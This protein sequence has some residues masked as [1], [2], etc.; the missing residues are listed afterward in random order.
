MRNSD[1]RFIFGLGLVI[2]GLIFGGWNG[3]GLA[4]NLLDEKLLSVR[5]IGMGGILPI[6]VH[7]PSV[8][9]FNPAGLGWLES[10]GLSVEGYN[11][12]VSSSNLATTLNIG[13]LGISRFRREDRTNHKIG[14]GFRPLPWFSWGLS[15][16]FDKKRGGSSINAG[17][18]ISPRPWLD[19]GVYQKSLVW[20]DKKTQNH[21]VVSLTTR[22]GNGKNLLALGGVLQRDD[23]EFHLGFEYRVLNRSAL[24]VGYKVDHFT[25]GATIGLSRIL[26]FDYAAELERNGEIIHYFGLSFG[27][28]SYFFYK[29]DVHRVA[30]TAKL[31]KDRFV[32]VDGHNVHYV[33]SGSG[34]PLILISGSVATYR[35]WNPLIASLS[36]Y[37]RVLAIE[38]LGNG[39]SDKPS[40]RF[41]Y[42][43]SEQADLIKEF[44]DRLEIEKADFIGICYGGAIAFQFAKKYP[45]LTNKVIVIEGFLD[46]EEFVKDRQFL[47]SLR[48]KPVVGDLWIGLLRT[49]LLDEPMARLVMG[50]SF[51]QMSRKDQKKITEITYWN[52]ANATRVFWRNLAK[53]DQNELKVK[54]EDTQIESPILFLMGEKSDFRKFL[55]PTLQVLKRTVKKLEIV[56]VKGG[57]HNLHLQK[58]EQCSRLI[59]QFLN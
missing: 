25:F 14:Y 35:V 54:Y 50:K 19:V 12:S 26:D 49:G 9:F 42:S 41:N 17:I 24:R 10:V 53:V 6:P 31:G 46:I 43:F 27:R 23:F 36:R 59:L 21:E 22:W 2:L 39:D 47:L 30:Q 34:K 16:D 58:P 56:T 45:N 44:M 32:V 28:P 5:A 15:S 1:A 48:G 57:I 20:A 55:K 38:S 29:N 13:P 3:S 18:L 52:N 33:E 4:Q 51:S 37:R 11:S 40:F 7:D 8:L